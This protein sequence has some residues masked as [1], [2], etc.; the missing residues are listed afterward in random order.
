LL[1]TEISQCYQGLSNGT[2]NMSGARTYCQELNP[3]AHFPK[4]QPKI[5]GAIAQLEIANASH[6]RRMCYLSSLN[7]SMRTPRK[8][9][10]TEIDAFFLILVI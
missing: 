7:E 1:R 3:N 10:G 4:P 6:S 5:G 9:I 2:D 8:S